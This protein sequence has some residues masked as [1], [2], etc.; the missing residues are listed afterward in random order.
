MPCL[1]VRRSLLL[2]SLAP[3]IG[4][5]LGLVFLGE[6]L[7]LTAWL[8]VLVTVLGVAWVITE[9]TPSEA[10]RAC[11]LR[12]GVVFGLAFAFCQAGGAVLS[13]LVF[14]QTSVSPLAT[15]FIRLVA[16]IAILVLWLALRRQKV[17]TLSLIHI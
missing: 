9:Q 2:G 3:P 6:T 11:A 10:G 7:S 17:L 16:G 1:G 14:N 12:R 8:G 4:G 15:A 13:R 5:I